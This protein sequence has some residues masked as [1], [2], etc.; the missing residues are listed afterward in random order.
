MN[1]ESYMNTES[2]NTWIRNGHK[3]EEVENVTQLQVDILSVMVEYEEDDENKE[4]YIDN[5][6]NLESLSLQ[7]CSKLPESIGNLS[8]L[9]SIYI[10][11]SSLESLPE[12]I[13]NLSNLSS[14][15]INNSDDFYS[16]EL[17][18]SIG[19]LSN[20]RTLNLA[21]N[22]LETLPESIGNL[23]KLMILHLENNSLETL[24][25]SIGNLSQLRSLNLKNNSLETLPESIGNLSQLRT[26]KLENNNNLTL[27]ESIGNLHLDRGNPNRYITP[28]RLYEKEE[29]NVKRKTE[30][31]IENMEIITDK[32]VIT[33]EDKAM[34]YDGDKEMTIQQY[35]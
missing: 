28:R 22:S 35:K 16:L 4:N 31:P 20:L 23:S 5:F 27:P 30:P 25:E 2:F 24:P 26:L 34:D 14:L 8:K 21:N 11:D 29:N 32:I 17:P 9:K 13:G 15:T 6:L 1:T 7:N 3:K 10:T 18:E 33:K 12:S 19:N